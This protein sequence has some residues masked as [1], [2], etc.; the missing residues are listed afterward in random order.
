LQ[1]EED[2]R[3]LEEELKE[4][5]NALALQLASGGDQHSGKVGGPGHWS[6]NSSVQ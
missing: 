2:K 4:K 3:S 6:N 1:L 5:K